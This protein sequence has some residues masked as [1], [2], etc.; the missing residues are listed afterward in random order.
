M[1]PSDV[2]WQLYVI[3]DPSAIEPPDRYLQVAR[4]AIAGG[5]GVIQLRDK[6]SSVRELL[7]RARLL[8]AEC[9]R[10]KVAFIVNDR[11]DVAVAAR[12]DGVHLGPDDIPVEDAR[13]VAP[14]LIV[15]GSAGTPEDARELAAAGADYLGSGSVFDAHGSKPD[16]HHN[17]GLQA[18]A[19]V[20][21]AVDI[22]VV[23][24][25]GID[26][27][28]AADVA[29]TGAAGVAVIRAVCAADDPLV[30]SR[31]LRE[32]FDAAAT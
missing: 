6:E 26:L 4:D 8:A 16:A 14:Q 19:E 12:A 18:L 20:V 7:A 21:Q 22:P 11:V 29:A 27:S 5:A 3:V 23:G 2:D 25:G 10:H 31:K 32:T 30:A 13:R 17:R 1:N 28:N 24:I 9:K 15:G